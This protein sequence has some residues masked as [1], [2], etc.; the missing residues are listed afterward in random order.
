MIVRFVGI[1]L[2]SI[3]M[4]NSVATAAERTTAI[5]VMKTDGSQV[6]RLA[7]G[8][9]L[10]RSTARRA[11]PTMASGWPSTP[12]RDPRG[13]QVLHRP[14]RRRRLDAKWASTACPTGRPTTSS[15]PATIT[16]EIGSRESG[17]K[18]STA[19]D[20]IGWPP[21]WSAL[22]ARRRPDRI[23]GGNGLAIL[24]LVEE[25]GAKLLDEPLGESGG[26][27]DWSPDG[28]RLA[29]VSNRNNRRELWIIDGQGGK[30]PAAP[31]LIGSL[32][33]YLAWSPD[34]KRLAIAFN[35]L[36]QLLEVDG[37]TRRSR[38][39]ARRAIA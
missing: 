37:R 4:A 6:R 23:V 28:K 20:A 39:P 35:H 7:A 10:R 9:R 19:R 31:R 11:G 16:A 38:F 24:D 18:I 33:G 1:L 2:V 13:V 5:Y 36:I 8:R 29:V 15:W 17:C 30:P 25:P 14:V 32:N 12:R 34:G 22:V 21:G 3:A 27:F 26:G